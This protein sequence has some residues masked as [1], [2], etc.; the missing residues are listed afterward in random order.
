MIHALLAQAAAPID[1][2]VDS[3]LRAG[4]LGICIVGLWLLWPRV[5]A[6]GADQSSPKRA[7]TSSLCAALRRP[8][9]SSSACTEL[10]PVNLQ[11]QW[12]VQAQFGGYYAA[13]DKGFYEEQCLDVTIL[14]GGVDIVPQTQL[15]QGAA[16]YAIAWVPKALASR[17]Q[18]A[19]IVRDR[20]ETL[21]QLAGR[22]HHLVG[23]L[24]PAAAAATAT[25]PRSQRRRLS[26]RASGWMSGRTSGGES[27]RVIAALFP[28]HQSPQV[29]QVAPGGTAPGIGPK[30][31]A[32]VVVVVDH[33]VDADALGQVV[34]AGGKAQGLDLAALEAGDGAGLVVDPLVDEGDLGGLG[35]VTEQLEIDVRQPGGGAVP[36]RP[37]HVGPEFGQALHPG[38]GQAAQGGQLA[39]LGVGAEHLDVFAH[40]ILQQVVR[41]ER[42]ARSQ[43]QLAGGAALGRPPLQALLHHQAGGGGRDVLGSAVHARIVHGP[44]RPGRRRVEDR[45]WRHG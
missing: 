43:A 38:G 14:E 6:M 15:A 23:G 37:A 3:L 22:E 27:G 11:L 31:A 32:Q 17:E 4:P 25:P 28:G 20:V 29:L 5:A 19:G 34:A 41:R 24:A 42:G 45:G 18:G 26:V 9:A 13:K 44:V 39:G 2:V 36:D 21:E 7:A 8:S 33:E 16:D 10:M 35:V 1:P 12:F 40:R 30:G